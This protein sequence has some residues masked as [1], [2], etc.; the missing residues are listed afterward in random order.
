MAA[1]ILAPSGEDT[2]ELNSLIIDCLLRSPTGEDLVDRARLADRLLAA[3]LDER[4]LG[5]LKLTAEILNVE[6]Q[7]TA[8]RL[9][10]R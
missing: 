1:L 9:M 5:D 2:P 6:R 7:R 10:R 4:T 3:Q 8:H